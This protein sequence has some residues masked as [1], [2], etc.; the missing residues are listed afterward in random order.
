MLSDQ[1]GLNS[2]TISTTRL[3]QF[4]SDASH[5][6]CSGT[7][8]AA[9]RLA[10]CS[11]SYQCNAFLSTFKELESHRLH[12]RTMSETVLMAISHAT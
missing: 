3:A 2:Q 7:R 9:F 1:L 12:V 11:F 8:Y 4:D 6:V 10:R 5:I